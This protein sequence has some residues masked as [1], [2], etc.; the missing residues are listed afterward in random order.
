MQCGASL[1]TVERDAVRARACQNIFKDRHDVLAVHGDSEL[2]LRAAGPFDLLF[3]DGLGTYDDLHAPRSDRIADLVNVGGYIIFDDIKV[4]GTLR[5]A[6]RMK[7]RFF[8][9]RNDF[10]SM[11]VRV[12]EPWS[13]L[14]GVR[15]DVH[16]EP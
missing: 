14:V 12:E 13:V 7:Q 4:H 5:Y 1:I 15:V 3:V 6:D 9:E 16:A 10:F 11:P 8:E 2:V